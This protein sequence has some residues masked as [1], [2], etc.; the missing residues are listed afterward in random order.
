MLTRFRRNLSYADVMATIAVFMALG[1]ASYAA[2]NLPAKSVGTKQ[3]KDHAVTQRKLS[4]AARHS[5][6]G[7]HGPTGPRGTAGPQGITGA[8]GPSDAYFASS[9]AL[10]SGGNT[11]VLENVPARKY[12]VQGRAEF[13]NGTSTP[14][15]LSCTAHDADYIARD[16]A[17]G[18]TDQ[19]NDHTVVSTIMPLELAKPSSILLQCTAST[20][21]GDMRGM[22]ISA[23]RV[24]AI[25]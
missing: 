3:I 6:R 19:K 4:T 22:R 16:D 13:I 10:A 17:T 2:V 23:I 18:T 20:T 14:Q 21:M 24:G 7:S 25:H 5:L 11:I 12:I 9:D 1:G 8:R 15:T